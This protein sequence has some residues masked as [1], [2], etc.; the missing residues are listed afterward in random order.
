MSIKV[1]ITKVIILGSL[2][3][4]TAWAGISSKPANINLGNSPLITYNTSTIPVGSGPFGI[5]VAPNHNIF[6]TN[7]GSNTVSV[8]YGYSLHVI[9][10]IN[11]GRGPTGVA[12]TPNGQYAY[13]ANSSDDT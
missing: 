10:T 11:V 9:S 5:A 8:I 6:V 4:G 2:F 13:V 12:I 1:V 3:V 7:N